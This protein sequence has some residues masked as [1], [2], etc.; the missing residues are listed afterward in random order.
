ML[1]TTKRTLH[2]A[3]LL[4]LVATGFPAASEAAPASLIHRTGHE[5]AFE[6]TGPGVV[7]GDNPFS[8]ADS[9]GVGGVWVR[10]LARHPG[11][12]TVKAAHS[13]L[14]AKSVAINV[15]NAPRA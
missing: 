2:S 1:R 7:V 10:T 5:V 3:S 12:V 15:K 4:W 8:L 9:G 13:T 14:G 6:V 11:R